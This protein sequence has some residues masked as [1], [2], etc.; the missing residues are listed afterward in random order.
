MLQE[1]SDISDW[2]VAILTD[3]DSIL[4]RFKDL[5]H[6]FKYSD[7]S[8]SLIQFN[9]S[10]V[11]KLALSQNNPFAILILPIDKH[12]YDECWELIDT[13][14]KSYQNES[15]RLLVF[16]DIPQEREKMVNNNISE[17]QS[18]K[19]ICEPSFIKALNICLKSYSALNAIAF[20]IKNIKITNVPKPSNIVEIHE[21]EEKYRQMLDALNVPIF[22]TRLMDNKIVFL[23]ENAKD[24]FKIFSINQAMAI[25]KEELYCDKEQHYNMSKVLQNKQSLDNYELHMQNLLGQDFYVLKSSK[26]IQYFGVDCELSTFKD[27][28]PR[29]KMEEELRKLA[30]QDSLTGLH[31]RHHFMSLGEKEIKRSRRLGSKLSAMMIDIDHFKKINDTYGHKT[32]DDVLKAFANVFK[33]VLRDID[34]YGRLGGEEFGVILPETPFALAQNIGERLRNEIKNIRIFVKNEIVKITASI[35]VTQLIT[36]EDNMETLLHRA[37]MGL[38]EAKNTGRDKVIII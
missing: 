28:T 29:K 21:N 26:I 16:T 33:T 32:G 3:E 22:I 35:G 11:A 7:K 36:D 25:N 31:N 1:N 34:V 10:E 5:L 14:R 24:K 23:N 20:S 17:S 12:N 19:N 18:L 15:I 6:N 13:I 4:N 38:Y 27:I 2:Q 37:D 30:T 9:S 8:I